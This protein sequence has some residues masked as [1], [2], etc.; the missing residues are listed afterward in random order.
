MK[1]TTRTVESEAWVI[2]NAREWSLAG[3]RADLLVGLVVGLPF[4]A[5]L[6]CTAVGIVTVIGWVI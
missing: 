6:F 5:L 2:L 1:R 3:W 4:T